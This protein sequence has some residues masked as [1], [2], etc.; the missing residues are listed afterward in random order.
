MKKS[1]IVLLIIFILLSGYYVYKFKSIQE[2]YRQINESLASIPSVILPPKTKAPTDV[3]TST[4]P[5]QEEINKQ[6]EEIQKQDNSDNLDDIQ[7]DLD[8]T[9]I[10]QDLDKDLNA[11]DKD[12]QNLNF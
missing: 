7:K 12:L 8:N 11:L 5:T 10:D 6:V 4:L 2:A 3:Q 1:L 9:E